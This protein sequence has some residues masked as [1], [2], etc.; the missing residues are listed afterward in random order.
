MESFPDRLPLVIG[1]TGHRDLRETDLLELEAKVSS[2]I[3]GLR[4]D[5]LGHDSETPIVVL[6]SL[7]E[8]ADRLVARVALAQGASLIA[9]M[10]MPVAEYRRDFVPGLKPGNAAEFD[11][12]LLQA[13]AVPVMPFT[14]GNSIE[15]VREDAEKRKEQYRAVGVFIVQ[16]CNVLIALW[17]GDSDAMSAGGTA[18]V[19]A[20]KRHGIPLEVSGCARSSLDAAEVGPVVHVV[21]PR[22]RPDN[23]VDAVDLRPW[24]EAVIARYRGGAVRR[25]F[26]GVRDFV[27]SVLGRDVDDPRAR[28]THAEQVELEAWEDFGRLAALT[29]RFNHEAARLPESNG[30]LQTAQSI[31]GLFSKARELSRVEGGRFVQDGVSRAPRWCRLYALADVLAQLRQVRFKRDWLSVYALAFFALLC[32]GLFSVVDWASNIILVLYS[33][34]FVAI[35]LVFVRAR[36]RN[37]QGH[38]LDYRALAEALRV[39]VYWKLV[40]IDGARPVT[41]TAAGPAGKATVAGTLAALAEAYPIKQPNELAW[42]KVSLRVL[43][44]VDITERPAAAPGP[45]AP[46]DVAGGDAAGAHAI[47]RDCWVGSQAA[48][49]RQ[50]SFRHSRFAETLENGAVVF[51]VAAPFLIVPFVIAFTPAPAGGQESALRAFLLLVSGLLPGLATVLNGYSDKLALKVQAGH[52]DRMRMLFERALQ[53]L[54]ADIDEPAAASRALQV[55]TELGREAL[56][57]HAEWVS[58]YRQ[59]PIEP[60]K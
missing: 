53:L 12:L 42:V 24:G 51:L 49:F 54:P 52:Y 40:G 25:T 4:R 27:A 6:S 33:L 20:F 22:D 8:G 28:L 13:I 31:D 38:F 46:A 17:D 7:A 1:V 50:R 23:S 55:Y 11:D 14:P 3:A 37:H 36:I 30:T 21:T 19:V 35:F 56:T 29:R 26:Q 18:E 15:A 39:T 57:E 10:P 16:H 2:V 48:F 58:I 44:L 34:A 5:Y 47:V 60:P 32:F 9:P 41:S 45:A 43:A 59:R